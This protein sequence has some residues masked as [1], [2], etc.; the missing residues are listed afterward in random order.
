MVPPGSKF[1]TLRLLYGLG[2]SLSRKTTDSPWAGLWPRP[3]P[4]KTDASGGIADGHL[5][6]DLLDATPGS[7]HCRAR[8]DGATEAARLRQLTAVVPVCGKRPNAYI[9]G[10]SRRIREDDS[11]SPD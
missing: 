9:S 1:V 8:R 5:Q 10:R 7:D 4:S 3:A 6:Q 2:R 11:G